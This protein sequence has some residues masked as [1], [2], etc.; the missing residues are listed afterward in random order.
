MNNWQDITLFIVVQIIMLV[1][2]F[3]NF[4]PFFPGVVVMWLAALGYALLH[5]WSTLGVVLFVIITLLMIFSTLVDNLLMG[6]GA[7]KGGATWWTI[8]IALVA[9][10]VFTFI[11]PPFG[12]LIAAPLTVLMIEWIRLRDFKLAL[13]SFGGMAAGYGLSYLARFGIGVVVMLLWWLWVWKG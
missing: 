11:F 8:V 6:V 10:V 9:G 13:K 5:G 4:V 12:G 2:L 3:G 1:G 7:F